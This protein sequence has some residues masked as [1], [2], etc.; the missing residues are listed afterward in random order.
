[1]PLNEIVRKGTEAVRRR[2][3]SL[4]LGL[5]IVLLFGALLAQQRAERQRVRAAIRRHLDAIRAAGQPLTGRELW[6][7]GPHPPSERNW[8]LTFEPLLET[9]SP[10]P[11]LAP[12]DFSNPPSEATLAALS[13]NLRSN[14]VVLDIVLQ[15]DLSGVE[16]SGPQPNSD[17]VEAYRCPRAMEFITLYFV[18]CE[19]AV[20]EASIGHP[21]Q[22]ATALVR[23][24]ETAHVLQGW[25]EAARVHDGCEDVSL[26]ALETTLK[27]AAFSES[28]LLRLE[29]ALPRHATNLLHQAIV[30]DRVGG[31]WYCEMA[32]DRPEEFR[33]MLASM[34]PNAPKPGSDFKGF[35]T[36]LRQRL[37][38][39]SDYLGLL[40]R[41]ARAWPSSARWPENGPLSIP[42]APASL[43][44]R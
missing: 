44:N 4:M 18:L 43:S 27:C 25:S 1:M 19:K 9:K 2:R 30:Q 23:S 20:Y 6:A 10:H 38:R 34:Y 15:T 17:H 39:D 28:D 22:A 3:W 33:K 8:R 42:E 11:I 13:N 40:D 37:Y 14:A 5:G 7:S 24:F 31:I 35:L 41:Y 36:F 21:E 16:W 12:V 32:R 29:V 26:R